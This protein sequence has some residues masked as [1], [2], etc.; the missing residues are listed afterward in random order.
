MIIAQE[1]LVPG[2]GIEPVHLA[3]RDFKS[4]VSPISPSGP[5][6]ADYTGE[7]Q[8]QR[9]KHYRYAFLLYAGAAEESELDLNLGKVALT[10]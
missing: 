1:C 2:T 8:M 5:G 10:N 4:L 7:A 3:A 6:M 9:G